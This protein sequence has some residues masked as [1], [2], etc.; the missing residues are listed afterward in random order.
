MRLKWVYI[1]LRAASKIGK[2]V[3][4]YEGVSVLVYVIGYTIR[5]YICEAYIAIID[6][7][8]IAII[9]CTC[10]GF[11]LGSESSLVCYQVVSLQYTLD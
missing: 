2:K 9:S 4:E 1:Q 8:E 7:W 3:L 5:E 11:S 10:L 6:C